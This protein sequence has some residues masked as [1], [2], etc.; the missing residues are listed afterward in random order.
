MWEQFIHTRG[1]NQE[2]QQDKEW[3]EKDNQSIN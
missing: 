2:I 3:S 1:T